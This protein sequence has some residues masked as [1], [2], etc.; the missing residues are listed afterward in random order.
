MKWE[1]S[2]TISQIQWVWLPAPMRLAQSTIIQIQNTVVA[3][4]KP[5]I[6]RMSSNSAPPKKAP[7]G[8][9][10]WGA[11]ADNGKIEVMGWV[12]QKSI[13][14]CPVIKQLVADVTRRAV[15][16]PC[17]NAGSGR[18]VRPGPHCWVCC[19]VWAAAFSRASSFASPSAAA[20]SSASF[21][22]R[23]APSPTTSLCTASSTWKTLACSG[24]VVLAVR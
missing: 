7:S 24:P 10:G 2:R 1:K 6:G 5:I 3:R 14:A 23:P 19:A 9:A 8:S 12:R 20:C 15:P 11:S 17:Q 22:E 13:P 18:F 4:P 16:K 21:L